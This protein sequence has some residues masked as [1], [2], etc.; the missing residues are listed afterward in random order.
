[1]ADE[2]VGMLRVVLASNSALFDRGMDTSAEKIKGFEAKVASAAKGVGRLV[3]DF[4]GSKIITEAAKMAAAVEKVGGASKL[5]E[6]E[7]ARV[8]RTV[9]AA[10]AKY[11]ALGT[12]APAVLQK[13]A[14]ETRKV[15]AETRKVESASTSWA[16]KLDSVV[17]GAVAGLSAVVT[18]FALN[19]LASAVR[20]LGD[21]LVR[22]GE[23]AAMRGSF[24][25]LSGG[26]EIA[27]ARV[28][29]IRNST[30]G[31]VS[32]FDIMKA[33][34]KAMLLDLGLTTTQMGQLANTAVVLGRAMGQDATKSLDDLITALGRSSPMILDNLGLSVK[35]GEANEAYARALGKT[36]AALTDAEKKQ[37][38]M[39]AAMEAA[40]DKVNTIGGLHLTAADRVS[41]LWTSFK[42]VT[43]AA[44]T[45]VVQLGAVNSALDTVVQSTSLWEALLRGGPKEALEAYRRSTGDFIPEVHE[46]AKAKDV[47]AGAATAL[48]MSH[49]A[50][51]AIEEKLTA[52]VRTGTE[53]RVAHTAAVVQQGF[54][55]QAL[56]G[57]EV[58]ATAETA[59]LAAEQKRA[60]QA[61]LEMHLSLS[62]I[63]TDLVNQVPYLQSTSSMG[64]TKFAGSVQQNTA[65]AATSSG[66]FMNTLRG[67]FGGGGGDGGGG[68]MSQLLGQIGPQF[69]AAFMGPGS[70]GDKMKAFATQAAGTLMGMIPGVGPWLQAF[71]GPIIEGLSKLASKAKDILSGIFGGPS[72]SEKEQRLLVAEFEANLASGLTATQ[73]LE[74]GGESWK[75][76]VIAI[77]D[78][79][80]AQGRTA[81]E[82]EADA[83]RLWESSKDGAGA[84]ARVIEEI[85]RKMQELTTGT[86]TID[87]EYHE[88]NS[89]GGGGDRDG[90]NSKQPEGDPGFAVG[91]MGRFGKWFHQFGKETRTAL[92]GVQAVLR[93]EDALP[94]A[95]SVL[96][97]HAAVPGAPESTTT[98]SLNILPVIMGGNKSPRE[99]GQEAVQHLASSGLPMN[100]AG[101]TTA[102]EQVIENYMRTYARA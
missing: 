15:E 29:A 10:L 35:V 90:G 82:A 50:M 65:A 73:K 1:V 40:A 20:G 93:P 8:N 12:Q 83:K 17:T 9:E 47:A 91:T 55:L 96:S 53:A 32:S 46:L 24:V 21:F 67:L 81:A 84:T 7:Q 89:P 49:E 4:D 26:I 51:R 28:K 13:L 2:T 34:N 102:F 72:K 54:D 74:A 3:S 38:F 95:A 64:W 6:A 33:S 98:N 37:A 36:S 43:D 101:V 63:T 92:H 70:A 18:N 41:Q 80:I 75:E 31:L 57:W 99:I 61:G 39:N 59:R 85:R 76:T 62:T 5:T 11:A 97:Q 66:G 45:W 16:G 44:A 86:H 88:K 77:R 79:Y 68:K 22:G 56:A 71:S 19:A 14:D 30:Q 25:A 23:V 87:I 100:E 42:N 48:G 58:K 60:A 52:T 94:F 78:A 27:D 69:A